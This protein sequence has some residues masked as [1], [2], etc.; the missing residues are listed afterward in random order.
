MPAQHQESRGLHPRR[1]APDDENTPG[2][3]RRT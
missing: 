2:L 3:A 1:A